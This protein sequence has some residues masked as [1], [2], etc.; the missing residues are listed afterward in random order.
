MTPVQYERAVGRVFEAKGYR[1]EFTGMTNDA[2]I[3]VIARKG[4]EV[5]AIQ[6]K[7]YGAGRPVNREAI[8]QLH[9]ACAFH[10][11]TRAVL[12]TDGR[13]LENAVEAAARLGIEILHFV[14]PDDE[15][16]AALAIATAT[17]TIEVSPNAAFDAAWQAYVMPLA[18]RHLDYG[19]GSSSLIQ[20]VD[21]SGLTRVTSSGKP[22]AVKIEIFRLAFA[23]LLADGEV[24]RAWIN[25]NYTGRASAIIVR[26]MACMPMFR[27]ETSPLRLVR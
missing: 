26:V 11:C 16:T 12:A 17:S 7:M 3:D 21:W 10:D 1:V 25:D 18:G 5:I 4:A 23:K 24:S 20:S 13:C 19:D 14:P 8:F 9:G 2:G 6:A 15:I 27:L 22:Q